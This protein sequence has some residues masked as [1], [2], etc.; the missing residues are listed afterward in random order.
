MDS[1]LCKKINAICQRLKELQNK[2]QQLNS[3]LNG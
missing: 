3:Q 1:F 2:M